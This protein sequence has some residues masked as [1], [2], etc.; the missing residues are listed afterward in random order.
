MFC[1][2]IP[3]KGVSISICVFL[4]P[5]IIFNFFYVVWPISFCRCS[6]IIIEEIPN[7]NAKNPCNKCDLDFTSRKLLLQHKR[8]A[9]Y[10][11]LVCEFCSEIFSEKVPLLFHSKIHIQ[12][13]FYP[14]SECGEKFDAYFG[15]VYHKKIHGKITCNICGDKFEGPSFRDLYRKHS[16]VHLTSCDICKKHI[17]LAYIKRHKKTVHKEKVQL[18]CLECGKPFNSK[19]GLKRHIFEK[20]DGEQYICEFCGKLF[21]SLSGFKLHL[22]LHSGE[23]SYICHVCGKRFSHNNLLKLHVRV[24]T[25]ERPHVCKFCKRSY[26]QRSSLA[27]HLKVAHSQ[28]R[29]FECSIC[30]KRFA[31]KSLLNTHLKQHSNKCV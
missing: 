4:L 30:Q 11:Q 21:G 20:H 7:G 2:F 17:S 28:E 22:H 16:R 9:H 14:C 24:H 6:G 5:T 26:S 27:V 23:K 3:N 18:Y 8:L 15:L 31:V 25:R 12:D 10:K 29:P 13:G 19:F 1:Y